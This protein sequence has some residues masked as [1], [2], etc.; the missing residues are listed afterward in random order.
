MER[1]TYVTENGEVLF[2]PAD[3]PDDEGMTITRL[4]KNGRYKDLEEIA[5]R[6]ANREQAE[7]QGLL[8]RVS[9][10]VG[11]KV[12]CIENKQVWPCTIEKISISKSNGTWIEISFPKEMPDI[13]SMEFYPNDIGKTVFLTH[14]DA[15][16]KLKEMEKFAKETENMENKYLYRAKRIKNIEWIQVNNEWLQGYLYGI[17][18]RKFILWGT[19]NGIPNMVEVNPKT[20]CQCIG[21]E[22]KNGKLIWEHDIV[23]VKYTDGQEYYQEIIEVTYSKHGFAPY[24]WEYECD[25][26]DLRCEILEIEVIGDKFDNPELLENGE[27]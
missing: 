3:L 11:D 10:R 16:A 26:C 14:E 2:H 24:S 12:Y 22:D 17:R 6:L 7:E 1:L 18:K 19:N 21:I 5:E 23:R 13:T 25:G 27:E 9:C 20:V 4:A 15:E 8:L